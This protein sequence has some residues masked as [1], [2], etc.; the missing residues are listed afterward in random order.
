MRT[1]IELPDEYIDALDRIR[2]REGASR[3]AIIRKAVEDY[4]SLHR[5]R[6]LADKP[7][8]GAWRKKGMDGLSFQ[9]SIRGE[10]EQ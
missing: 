9:R 4:I 1:I 7:G 8:F 10:W 5:K 3:A 2:D 6:S